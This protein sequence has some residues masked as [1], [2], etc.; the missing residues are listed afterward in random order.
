M[1]FSIYFQVIRRANATV[2]GLAAGIFTRDIS[3]VY[4]FK[5]FFI[6]SSG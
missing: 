2:Y 6:I 3:T 5:W 4:I 1:N